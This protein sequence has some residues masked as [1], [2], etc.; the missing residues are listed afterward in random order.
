MFLQGHFIDGSKGRIFVSQ[1]GQ[2]NSSTAL[3][4]LPSITEELNLSRAVL[5]KQCQQVAESD[6]DSFIMDYYGSGDSEGDFE[7]ATAD[8]WIKDVIAAGTW[9]MAQGYK[10]IILLGV[11]VGALLMAAHQSKL[12]EALP[13]L[14]QILWKPVTNG[15][16]FANQLIRVK[17]ANQMMNSADKKVNWRDMILSG[18]YTEISGYVITKDFIE[19]LEC[20]CINADADWESEVHW[21]ELAATAVTPAT[22][23]FEDNS[24]RITTYAIKTPAF[25]QVPEIF[26]L[27]EL[28]DVCE[29]IVNRM[30]L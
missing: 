9:L 12:H 20:L 23:K 28:T 19:S 3:L 17:Q 6:I 16:L 5:A 29:D 14:G 24:A 7:G 11:R 22:K 4:C 10:N 30:K 2:H 18:E 8:D 25:W 15:K 27:P 1:F 26:E 13:I 21:F